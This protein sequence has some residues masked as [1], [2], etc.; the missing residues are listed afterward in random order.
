MGFVSWVKEWLDT[1]GSFKH[2]YVTRKTKARWECDSLY[3][4]FLKYEWRFSCKHPTG[5]HQ[6]GSKFTETNALIQDLRKLLRAAV[7][8]GDEGLCISAC[9]TILEWGGVLAGNQSHIMG[10]VSLC[11]YLR[12]AQEELK[13]DTYTLGGK[14]PLIRMTSGFSKIYSLL[15]D[16]FIIYDSRV[17]AALCLLV[18]NY[19]EDARIP[20]IPRPL[21]FRIG[22][23]RTEANRNP[24]RGSHV[25][26]ML[27][28][29]NSNHYIDSNMR[30]NWLV[31]GI[32]DG[33]NSQF[34]NHGNDAMVALQAALF[35]IGYDVGQC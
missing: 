6:S 11:N 20:L 8:S 9:L 18:R 23:S 12:T 34:N 25:F 14:L 19:C 4:A 5:E 21:Q 22:P 32:L 7:L 13:E 3:D 1:P 26:K 27:S 28:L 35:M 15:L 24:S 16:D 2:Q 30:A 17:A 31:K 29:G 33:S 10:N